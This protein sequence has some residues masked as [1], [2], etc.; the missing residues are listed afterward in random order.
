MKTIKNLALL[1]LAFG[2]F[3]F[4]SCKKKDVAPAATA[5]L[6]AT[7]DGVVTE[8]NVNMKG[9][10]YITSPGNWVTDVQGKASDG[11]ILGISFSGTPVAS[12]TYSDADTNDLNRPVIIYQKPTSSDQYFNDHDASNVPSVTITS[13]T[14]TTLDGTFKGRLLKDPATD[15]TDTIAITNGKFHI[16]NLMHNP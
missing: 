12:K 6:V 1:S 7:I 2:V 8:F 15:K 3:T 4:S 13:V 5:T 14:S 11:T 16:S 9:Q 10:E